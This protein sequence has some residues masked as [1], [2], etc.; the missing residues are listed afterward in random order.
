M[1]EAQRG[2]THLRDAL[3]EVERRVTYLRGVDHCTP[4]AAREGMRIRDKTR[5]AMRER[6]QVR[7]RGVRG[8]ARR[9]VAGGHG[10]GVWDG[11]DELPG[12]AISGAWLAS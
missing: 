8:G 10:L 4:E 2:S 1:R 5:T 3:R 11:E 7:C 6:R 12:A 9:S